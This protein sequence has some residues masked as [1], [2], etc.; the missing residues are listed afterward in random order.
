MQNYDACVVVHPEWPFHSQKDVESIGESSIDELSNHQSSVCDRL[1]DYANHIQDYYVKLRELDSNSKLPI[2]AIPYF[3]RLFNEF[4]R[5]FNWHVLESVSYFNP[6][7]GLDEICEDIGKNQDEL[8][9][10]VCGCSYRKCLASYSHRIA[11][12]YDGPK[13]IDGKESSFIANPK[14]EYVYLSPEYSLDI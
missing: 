2:Y 1:Y 11:R 8:E 4:F 9:L 3:N 6:N 12:D 5:D 7:T 10:L 13:R 14:V